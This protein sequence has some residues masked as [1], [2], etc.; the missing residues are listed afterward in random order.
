MKLS[1]KLN[2]LQIGSRQLTPECKVCLLFASKQ[3]KLMTCRIQGDVGRQAYQISPTPAWKCTASNLLSMRN[4][5]AAKNIK[6]GGNS[7]VDKTVL[8]GKS[9]APYGFLEKVHNLSKAGY[10]GF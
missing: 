8:E 3:E 5:V 6:G 2:L 7:R 9:V 10:K 1:I 4:K